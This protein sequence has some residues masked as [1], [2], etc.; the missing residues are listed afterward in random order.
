[1]RF[2]W[3]RSGYLTS[4]KATTESWPLVVAAGSRDV[5]G[6]FQLPGYVHVLRKLPTMQ[7]SLCSR[8]HIDREQQRRERSHDLEQPDREWRKRPGGTVHS[9]TPLAL[10]S[11]TRTRSARAHDSAVA[12]AHCGGLYRAHAG[13]YPL[14][15]HAV[16]AVGHDAVTP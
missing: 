14:L 10:R 4:S 1:M 7:P 3:N 8:R 11:S 2:D 15:R 6:Y 12:W 13:Q 5:A 9:E 16:S